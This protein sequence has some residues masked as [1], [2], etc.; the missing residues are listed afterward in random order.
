ME[1]HQRALLLTLILILASSIS[2]LSIY[3]Y[4]Q[5]LEPPANEGGLELTP[6]EGNQSI[7]DL[8]RIPVD[9]V[10]CP[11]I[12]PF[13]LGN[14]TIA[15][16]F[17]L[18][19]F[20]DFPLANIS[21]LT[22]SLHL[23]PFPILFLNSCDVESPFYYNLSDIPLFNVSYAANTA[24]L[25]NFAGS[26][27]NGRSWTLSNDA[28]YY[29]YEGQ[30]IDYDIIGYSTF[31]QD[32]IIVI[33]LANISGF[34]P[35]S[36]YTTN[37]VSSQRFIFYPEEGVFYADDQIHDQYRFI[38]VHYTF[39]ESV[40]R[41]GEP[42][43]GE[44]YVQ[45]P[46]DVTDRTRSLARKIIGAYSSPYEKAEAIERYLKK[47]YEYYPNHTRAPP[48]HEPVDWFLFEEKRG[49][50]TN[51]A[52]AFVV[53]ARSV[54]LPSRLV[55]GFLITPKIEEQTVYASQAHAWAE[56]GF[57]ELGWIQFDPTSG[58]DQGEYVPRPIPPIE[59]VT[60]VDFISQTKVRKGEEFFVTGYV[61]T[62]SGEPVHEMPVEIYLIKIDG[63][64]GVVWGEVCG[65]GET[66]DGFFRITC[67]ALL[68]MESGAYHIVAHSLGRLPY[69]ESWSD[70]SV[71]TPTVTD[72]ASMNSTSIKRGGYFQVVGSVCT[73]KG[74][75]LDGVMVTIH[76][77]ETKGKGGIFCGEGETRDGTFD[78]TCQIPEEINIGD[79]H[80][81]AHAHRKGW[82]LESWSDPEIKVVSATD[83]T[84]AIPERIVLGKS[85]PV[86]GRLTE[87]DGTPPNGSQTIYI[88]IDGILVSEILTDVDGYFSAPLNF[89]DAGILTV[90]ALFLGSSYY[91]GSH[92]SATVEVARVRLEIYTESAF[93]RGE[94]LEFLGKATF[95]GKFLANEP[96]EIL[97]DE[98]TVGNTVTNSEGE[99]NY[100]FPLG[101]SEKLGYRRI[102]YNLIQLDHTEEQEVVVR[103]RTYLTS[104]IP[105]YVQVEK[106][107]TI[108]G[109]LTEDSGEPIPSLEVTIY[110]DDRST[111]KLVT[112]E[113]GHFY[114]DFSFDKLGA[115]TVKGA[116][117]G[118]D[119]YLNSTFLTEVTAT[120]VNLETYTNNTL[121]RGEE[122]IIHGQAWLGDDYLRG[123]SISISV[124][125]KRIDATE[126]D[127]LGRFNV[128]YYVSSGETPG[129]H[130][131]RYNL[132][133]FDYVKEQDVVVKIRTSLMIDAPSSFHPGDSPTVTVRLTDD[134]NQNIPNVAVH[135][136][137]YE[138]LTN[139]DGSA[140]FQVSIPQD[141]NEREMRLQARFDG[142]EIHLPSSS[143]A[144]M[145]I[146]EQNPWSW[147]PYVLL[148]AGALAAMIG[149]MLK[150]RIKNKPAEDKKG[151]DEK[152][153]AEKEEGDPTAENIEG[154]SLL[155]MALGFPE[156]EEPYPDV[157]GVNEEIKITCDVSD[158]EGKPATADKIKLLAN[159]ELISEVAASSGKISV[160][161][162]FMEKGNYEIVCDFSGN[163]LYK[164]ATAK[165]ELKIVD[166]RE[167]IV[168]LY[169]SF[170]EYL[171]GR[172][173]SI[174]ENATPREVQELALQLKVD[175]RMVENII[176]SFEEAQYSIHPINRKHY[177]TAWY[178]FHRI[179]G[180]E[181]A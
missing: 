139:I 25:S 46:N 146:N 107:S 74:I 77:N 170:L 133:D 117:L 104:Q 110:V 35:T 11:F 86:H 15:T 144:T 51:F 164:P 112:D 171:K 30:H 83:L 157:W 43:A 17:N 52:S 38:T 175:K 40:L 162:K 118:A 145:L 10:T 7:L 63:E 21:D 134:N 54:G 155:S 64:K 19:D 159:K 44:R 119:F 36:V 60:N 176:R 88:Y 12:T 33:P 28:I 56:V 165:K 181:I 108:A 120:L 37:L 16:P 70:E 131:I 55:A 126:T 50:C 151:E 153:K 174:V 72:I 173:V 114:Q 45:L 161:H 125:E 132:G 75:P 80:I 109:R 160:V 166:Y 67:E 58:E 81:I 116:F 150:R 34:I 135:L 147:L 121:V 93:I 23:G 49:V 127:A 178:A 142:T 152:K 98:K 20:A 102:L 53:M 149:F 1:E 103:A 14:T 76:M 95:G 22:G 128:S 85:V 111:G 69:L 26:I 61:T 18:S 5:K 32:R 31:S 62:K 78:V 65:E 48:G 115:H 41:N 158:N 156:I 140:G 167:E 148:L 66:Q 96:L 123:A 177:K 101:L 163:E 141:Y 87:E 2:L 154:A 39:E 57:K 13:D 168:A 130:K 91:E 143:T 106:P 6:Q 113:S 24:Y 105:R 84:L 3:S 172:G 8:P 9:E 169:H 89:D 79:Y 138:G 73:V 42:M 92:A 100:E 90:E 4:L 68:D 179:G 71:L 124:D 47:N 27:Y 59:T 122:A 99:F 180:A 137:E 94:D 29:Y 97:L 136:L 82:R 129:S